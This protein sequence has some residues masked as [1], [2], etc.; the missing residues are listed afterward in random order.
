MS[1]NPSPATS[2]LSSFRQPPPGY[3]EV[4]FYWW[5]GDPLT[6]ER[7]SWQLERLSGHA[8]SGLQ[9]NYAHSDRGGLSW[10]LTYPSEPPLFSEP[11]WELF[12]WFLDEANKRG[13]AVSLSDYTLGPGQQ[14]AI[15]NAIAAYPQVKASVLRH[16]V[17]E[18]SAGQQLD[19]QMPESLL[20]VVQVTEKGLID[21]RSELVSGRLALTAT[22]G[23]RL[24]AVWT[25]PRSPSIDPTHP[26]SGRAVAEHFF[27]P[28]D[29]RFPGRCGTGLN[30]FFSDELEFGYRGKV[31]SDRLREAFQRAKGY[32]ITP[33]LPGLFID[34][35]PR[36]PKLRMDYNDV[37]V[38]LSERHYFQPVYHWHESRGMTYGCDH[39]GRGQDVTEFGDYFR[40][41][42]WN[43][44]VGCDQPRLEVNLIKNKVASSIAHLYRR[45][46]VW[47][48]GFYSSGWGTS[49]AQL[50]NA[51]AA[52]FLQGHNLLTLHGLYYSTHGGW[53]EWAPPC[54]HFRMPYWA[55]GHMKPFLAATERLSYLL[56]Q[57]T[58]VADIAILYPV[59]SGEANLNARES[60]GVAFDLAHH[61]YAAGHDFDFADF[62]SIDHG[63]IRDGRLQMADESFSVLIL[64]AM[65]AI[66]HSTLCKARD[67]ARS[68]GVVIAVAP[69]PE[70]TDRT[71]FNDPEVLQIVHE[72]FGPGGLA[73]TARSVAEAIDQVRARVPAPIVVHNGPVPRAFVRRRVGEHTLVGL[74]GLP[75]NAEITVALTGEAV[76]LDP[77]TGLS[78]PL[79]ASSST[80]T[81][82]TFALRNHPDEL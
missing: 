36:T 54:N 34:A 21:L 17:R 76:R 11:W 44:G 30:Y 58:H 2:L 26:E 75:A 39:G 79:T 48:E 12:G 56:S 7:L 81:H 49:T 25:E 73:Y 77:L 20:S 52:N 65:R 5:L 32:D 57:G 45:P 66:R 16:E 50:W 51:V 31:W 37:F 71:G 55:G 63:S 41:Q 82:T 29:R 42:R 68:G 8:I 80:V 9:I 53:W 70:A 59:A 33:E 62:E 13:M 60:V 46:R 3:G 18:L 69:L 1:T 6:R 22:T 38:S 10:G 47:L 64:P 78:T 14:S 4:S 24:A 61:L 23:M 74:H 28:F 72:L 67:F 40:T 35:G 43:Q 27:G 19:W 15:D